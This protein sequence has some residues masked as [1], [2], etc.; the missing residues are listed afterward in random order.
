MSLLKKEKKIIYFTIIDKREMLSISQPYLFVIA[1][2]VLG[3]MMGLQ[4]LIH[5]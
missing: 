2:N 5:L 3:H 4:S 1:M